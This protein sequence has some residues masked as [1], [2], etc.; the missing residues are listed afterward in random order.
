MLYD[1]GPNL[2]PGVRTQHPIAARSAN[3]FRFS[4]M[5]Q[6]VLD[7]LE[8]GLGRPEADEVF[9]VSQILLQS[10]IVVRHY[11]RAGG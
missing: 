11:Q 8:K 7:L 4:W 1:V 10:L 9:P 5:L 2:P 6:I 3:G